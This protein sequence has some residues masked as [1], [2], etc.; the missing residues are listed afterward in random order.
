MMAVMCITMGTVLPR[1]FLM[2]RLT[3]LTRNLSTLLYWYLD[4]HLPGHRNTFCHRS[5][6]AHLFMHWSW[7]SGAMCAR[8]WDTNRDWHTMRDCNLTR[9]LNRY[10]LALTLSVGLALRRMLMVSNRTDY[11][12]CMRSMKELSISFRIG[13]SCGFSISCGISFCLSLDNMRVWWG[14][15]SSRCV[16]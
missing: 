12:T 5:V 1:N 16:N 6:M 15:G 2:N 13:I 8:N 3:H 9:G 4:W 11:C 7:H 14:K 10:T